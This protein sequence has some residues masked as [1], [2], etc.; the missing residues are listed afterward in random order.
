[1]KKSTYL[2]TQQ[3]VPKTAS[4]VEE[5]QAKGFMGKW[6]FEGREKLEPHT[7]PRKVWGTRNLIGRSLLS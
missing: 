5:G 1:M 2:P 4:V 7:W 3:N 6:G